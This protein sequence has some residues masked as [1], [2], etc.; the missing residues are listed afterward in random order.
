M[1]DVYSGE[2]KDL[3]PDNK[4]S[5]FLAFSYAIKGIMDRLIEFDQ[6]SMIYADVDNLPENILDHLAV[7]LRAMYYTQDLDLD[8]KRTI[9]KN[10]LIWYMGFGTV[11]TMEELMQI[12]FGVGSVVENW[13]F[14]DEPIGPYLF[15]VLTDAPD[16]LVSW[17]II[18][19]VAT[20]VDKIKNARSQLRRIGF[21]RKIQSGARMA[22]GIYSYY[23]QALIPILLEIVTHPQDI[24]GYSQQEYSALCQALGYGE[25]TMTWEC[26]IPTIYDWWTEIPF[27]PVYG[28]LILEVTDPDGDEIDY[29]EIRLRCRV[30]DTLGQRIY[31]NEFTLEALSAHEET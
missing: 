28:D 8:T 1:I 3:W 7:E 18:N 21:N 20:M 11:G 16:S 9:I 10:T 2:L 30:E 25:I 26:I 13:D 24:I 23:G 4:E 12:I 19:Y 15:D 5:E 29:D 31:S 6:H 14:D 17:D 22:T 27:D